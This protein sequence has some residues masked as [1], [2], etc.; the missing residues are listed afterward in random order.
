MATLRPC[1][2]FHSQ[3]DPTLPD[4]VLDV[5]KRGTSD[6]DKIS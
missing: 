3:A 5:S 6:F 1:Q 4:V 2:W